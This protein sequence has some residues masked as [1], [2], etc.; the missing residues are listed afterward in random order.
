MLDGGCRGREMWAGQ[1]RGRGG[2][3]P[4][5]QAVRAVGA[6]CPGAWGRA[7]VSHGCRG[8]SGSKQWIRRGPGPGWGYRGS[9][10]GTSW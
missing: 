4:W 9:P 1:A 3:E 10:C 5:R 6:E 7:V 8:W 2:R